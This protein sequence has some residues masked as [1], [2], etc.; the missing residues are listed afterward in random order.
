MENIQ[1]NRPNGA[2]DRTMHDYSK[3][4]RAAEPLEESK[5][6]LKVSALATKTELDGLPM[7]EDVDDVYPL[8][9][10][11]RT[12]PSIEQKTTKEAT[13][14]GGTS[15]DFLNSSPG[16]H[17]QPTSHARNLSHGEGA[18]QRGLPLENFD[19]VAFPIYRVQS[20]VNCASTKDGLAQGSVV[21]D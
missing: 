10:A 19:D 12:P 8:A 13:L 4:L 5:V 20:Q 17:L 2:T 16:Y 3:P 7:T 14:S 11:S 6:D 18:G 9:A 1:E 21:S 15:P